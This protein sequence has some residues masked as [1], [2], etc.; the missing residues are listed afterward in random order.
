M[1]GFGVPEPDFTRRTANE[2]LASLDIDEGRLQALANDAISNRQTAFAARVSEARDVLLQHSQRHGTRNPHAAALTQPEATQ[3]FESMLGRLPR[4][5]TARRLVDIALSNPGLRVV[6]ING[7]EV[8]N[9][10][11]LARGEH[12]HEGIGGLPEAMALPRPSYW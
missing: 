8:S 7:S 5:G 11:P 6:M 2:P 3:A 9:H 12:G 10:Y 1:V 4:E